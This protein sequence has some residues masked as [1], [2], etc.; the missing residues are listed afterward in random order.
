[1]MLKSGKAG[2]QDG[3]P[4]IGSGHRWLL[5]ATVVAVVA[6]VGAAILR[7]P[8]E[9]ALYE[10]VVVAVFPFEQPGDASDHL[11]ADLSKSVAAKLRGAPGI[12]TVSGDRGDLASASEWLEVA[13]S[14]EAEFALVGTIQPDSAVDGAT[15]WLVIPHLIRVADA[16]R[17]WSGRYSVGVDSVA[18]SHVQARIATDVAKAVRSASQAG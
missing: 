14:L 2:R 13:S 18:L 7:V 8:P 9:A 6:L 16:G 12:V 1:M 17:Q 4:P 11:P 3:K 10:R 15:R 5:P